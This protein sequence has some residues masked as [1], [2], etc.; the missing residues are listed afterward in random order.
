[1]AEPAGPAG[2]RRSPP[3][4]NCMVIESAG[5]Q[6]DGIMTVR[7]A[8]STMLVFTMLGSD[9]LETL[10][11]RGM[12]AARREPSNSTARVRKEQV[13]SVWVQKWALLPRSSC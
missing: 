11:L 13:P 9:P 3:V 8:P 7:G 6:H 2:G 10:L 5:L 1:M 4:L 12:T